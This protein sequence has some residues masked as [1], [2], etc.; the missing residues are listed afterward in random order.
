MDNLLERI[1]DILKP[2][3]EELYRYCIV[4]L[5]IAASLV[6]YV[7]E[8]N[9]APAIV[10]LAL[11]PMFLLFKLITNNPP[12]GWKPKWTFMLMGSFFAL[13]LLV[14]IYAFFFSTINRTLFDQRTTRAYEYQDKWVG[15]FQKQY[16]EMDTAI[17]KLNEN[18][19][20]DMPP[21]KVMPWISNQIQGNPNYM[22]AIPVYVDFFESWHDCINRSNCNNPEVEKYFERVVFEFWANYRCWVNRLRSNGYPE[23]YGKHIEY[24]YENR[25]GARESREKAG[26]FN[27]YEMCN[28]SD[29]RA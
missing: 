4:L 1:T 16:E 14:V 26:I 22:T 29:G 13:S 17:F 2:F 12:P 28:Y 10:V 6:V 27:P 23:D 8:S 25:S 15:L 21:E 24:W 11:I 9:L 5:L 3:N 7:K 19:I 20:K 18:A